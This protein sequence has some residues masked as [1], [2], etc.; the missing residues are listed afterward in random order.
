MCLSLDWWQ[1]TVAIK[2]ENAQFFLLRKAIISWKLVGKTGFVDWVLIRT[3]QHNINGRHTHTHTC[4][5][6][7]LCWSFYLDIVTAMPVNFNIHSLLWTVAACCIH[8]LFVAVISYLCS[9]YNMFCVYISWLQLCFW[10][11]GIHTCTIMPQFQ[12]YNTSR[13]LW[14]SC[15]FGS[16]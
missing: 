15:W 6:C 1:Y 3:E 5:F 11:T 4:I 7:P 2:A 16:L 14:K 12:Q 9:S 10:N 8:K 13:F